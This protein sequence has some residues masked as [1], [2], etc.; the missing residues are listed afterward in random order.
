[1]SSPRSLA[2]RAR[3]A[4]FM[5]PSTAHDPHCMVKIWLCPAGATDNRPSEMIFAQSTVGKAPKAGRLMAA[6]MNSSCE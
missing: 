4:A 1:M 3:N 5:A 6:V 2:L